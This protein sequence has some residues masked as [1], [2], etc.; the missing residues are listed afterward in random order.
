MNDPHF[1]RS[2]T[3]DAFVAEL[4]GALRVALPRELFQ[5]R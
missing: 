4:A 2:E 1:E 3:K 5:W